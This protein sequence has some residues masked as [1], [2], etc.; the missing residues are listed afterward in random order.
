MSLRVVVGEDSFLVRE[1]IRLVLESSPEVALLDLCPDRDSLLA[2][3]EAHRP[4]VVLTDIRMPPENRDE[5]IQVAHR[6]AE[7]HPEVGVVVVS[8][9][10]EPRY[11]L[12]LL[13]RGAARRG[14]LLKDRLSDRRQIVAAIE[15]V[16]A[17]GSVID[18]DVV[19]L[20]LSR[21]AGRPGSSLDPLT[22]RERSVLALV[23]EGLSN[24]AIADALVLSKRAV[25]KHVNA[26]FAKLGI[27]EDPAASRRVKAALLFLESGEGGRGG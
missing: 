25:E 5:G 8:Q 23:A 27:A 3:V 14:Y 17:G 15:T 13:E 24:Q 26:I 1:G 11:V 16:A 7:E 9:F 18:P 2:A 19:G 22:P 20:L 10:A 21:A 4:H 6:L 12:A